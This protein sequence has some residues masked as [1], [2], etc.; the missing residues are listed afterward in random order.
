MNIEDP[1][2]TAFL[3]NR[4]TYEDGEMVPTGKFLVRCKRHKTHRHVQTV[5][6]GDITYATCASCGSDAKFKSM[7][8]I[9]L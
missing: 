8:H 1:I 7:A 5:R 2:Y 4:E 6:P 3:Q 9:E